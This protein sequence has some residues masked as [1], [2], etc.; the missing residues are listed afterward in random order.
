MKTLAKNTNLLLL[1][2]RDEEKECARLFLNREGKRV[3][4]KST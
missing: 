1:K 4:R 2:E 3:E